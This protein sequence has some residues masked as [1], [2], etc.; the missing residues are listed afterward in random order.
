MAGVADVTPRTMWPPAEL[1]A[2]QVSH[3]QAK[4]AL[5]SATVCPVV[6]SDDSGRSLEVQLANLGGAR[7]DE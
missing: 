3:L 2:A 5:A 4:K 7:K 1:S 6:R